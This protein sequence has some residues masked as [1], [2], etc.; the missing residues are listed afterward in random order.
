MKVRLHTISVA[1]P[2][3]ITDTTDVDI[4]DGTLWVNVQ[5][6]THW[7]GDRRYLIHCVEP[8]TD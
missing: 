3:L 4:P 5:E 8:V 1:A 7:R 2:A 6:T